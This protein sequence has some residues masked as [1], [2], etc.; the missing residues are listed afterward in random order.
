MRC[1][2]VSE[3]SGA[4]S[5]RLAVRDSE[6]AIELDGYLGQVA[7]D[8]FKM[9]KTWRVI[10]EAAGNTSDPTPLMSHEYTQRKV[11]PIAV[12]RSAAG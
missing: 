2:A 7:E 6:T 9:V 8:L 11:T 5:S 4:D 10:L 1:I 3:N 12:E